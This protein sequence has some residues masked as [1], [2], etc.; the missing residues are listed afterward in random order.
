MS[1]PA[2]LQE[3]VYD[4]IKYVTFLFYFKFRRVIF[5]ACY[6]MVHAVFHTYQTVMPEE[7]K[8]GSKP[9]LWAAKHFADV[10]FHEQV[11]AIPNLSFSELLWVFLMW[12]EHLNSQALGLCFYNHRLPC[13]DHSNSIWIIISTYSS[14]K[15]F[16]YICNVFFMEILI[17]ANK[18]GSHCLHYSM[19]IPVGTSWH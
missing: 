8:I 19:C 17:K 3:K 7:R 5:Q 6:A 10:L 1:V 16:F 15:G 9:F 4:S 12:M 11:H 2:N 13:P 14:C 18:G